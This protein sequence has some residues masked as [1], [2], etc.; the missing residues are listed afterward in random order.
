MSKRVTFHKNVTRITGTLHEDQ[1]NFFFIFHSVLLRMR[2]VSDKCRENQNTH[3]MFNSG[4]SA[5]YEIMWENFVALDRQRITVWCM[6]IT[7]WITKSTNTRSVY[8]RGTYCFFTATAVP[9]TRL[10]LN[11]NLN[12]ACLVGFICRL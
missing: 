11:L 12:L 1:F 5:V 3:F 6:R 9:R 4:N 8:V 10:N 2:N 7:C